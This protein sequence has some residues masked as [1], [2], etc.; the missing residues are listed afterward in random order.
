[1]KNQK[2]FDLKKAFEKLYGIS[3]EKYHMIIEKKAKEKQDQHIKKVEQN[4]E[5]NLSKW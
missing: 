1:M 2:M 3:L 5:Q 4:I